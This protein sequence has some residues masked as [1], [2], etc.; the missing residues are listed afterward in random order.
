MPLSHPPKTNTTR[1]QF[2]QNMQKYFQSTT[3]GK[4]DIDLLALTRPDCIDIYLDNNDYLHLSCDPRLIDDDAY[5]HSMNSVI[6]KTE[7]VLHQNLL[8]EKQHFSIPRQGSDNIMA[9]VFLQ[10]ACLQYQVSDLLAKKILG[11]E[12]V[13][14][15]Q[16]GYVANYGL[17][18]ALVIPAKTHIYIDTAAHESLWQGAS[19]GIIH[20]IKHNSLDD[21]E[22]N[23]RRFG[24]G[25]IVVDSLYS[26]K[27]SIADLIEL[28][29]LK[30]QYN[31]MLVVD[32][33]HSIG[34]YGPHGCGLASLGNVTDRIDFITGSLAKAYCVRAGFIAGRV[35]E[36]LYVREK[37]S[38]STF[39]STL[40][41]WDIQRL[42]RAINIIYN[43]DKE[44]QRLM[45]IATTVRHAAVTLEFDVEQTPLPSSI[46]CLNAGPN[47][48]SKKL[49]SYFEN[50][51]ISGAIFIP[52]ATPL[53]RSMLRLTLHAGLSDDDVSRIINALEFIAQHHRSDLP[54]T[55]SKRSTT[56]LN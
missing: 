48:F 56:L 24:S 30:E 31:C 16:S 54:Y 39:S 21:L 53:N 11:K 7:K 38:S 42:Q 51:G 6:S 49:Q 8:D 20:K 1:E 37:S 45:H 9:G 52:P 17:L 13:Y 5:Q 33:S 40:M 29:N 14:L 15:A 12:S 50:V 22:Q 35:Q 34:L 55:F 46:L 23:L 28:C 27:G 26:G 47:L 3:T 43:A 25:I 44:R 2:L 18:Q 19:R 4:G 10:Q 32:E 36:V 41:N